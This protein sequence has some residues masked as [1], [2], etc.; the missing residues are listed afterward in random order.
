MRS[1]TEVQITL[2]FCPIKKGLSQWEQTYKVSN[3]YKAGNRDLKLP[4]TIITS[5]KNYFLDF[6]E[7]CGR[8]LTKPIYQSGLIYEDEKVRTS[9]PSALMKVAS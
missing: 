8:L 2:A 6:K 7:K 1:R 3:L 5:S 9:G 4:E